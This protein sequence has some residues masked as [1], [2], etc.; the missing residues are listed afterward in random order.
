MIQKGFITEM[1]EGGK[2]AKVQTFEG[3]ILDDVL[4]LYTYGEM[5][6]I[7]AGENS[8]VLL[9]C[10]LGSKTNVFGV[11]YDVPLQPTDLVAG[12]KSIGNFK[13]GNKIV[14]KANGDVE[15][16]SA[17][18]SFS[19]IVDVAGVY[20]VDGTQVVSNR[21]AAVT[22]PTGGATVDAEAR[23]AINAIIARMVAHGLIS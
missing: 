1:K 5:S 11:P 4:M 10:P 16:T 23:T 13:V 3:E 12:E 21:G 17:L 14:F 9:F 19:G 22:A 15:V 8:L 6:N 20:K 2:R 7:S 18:A